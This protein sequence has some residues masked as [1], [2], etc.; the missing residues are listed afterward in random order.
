MDAQEALERIAAFDDLTVSSE[1]L[2]M[3]AQEWAA[4][5]ALPVER[6]EAAAATTADVLPAVVATTIAKGPEAALFEEQ[7]YRLNRVIVLSELARAAERIWDALTRDE[8][9]RCV[10]KAAQDMHALPTVLSAK[11]W[12]AGNTESNAREAVKSVGGGDWTSGV[13]KSGSL[14]LAWMAGCRVVGDVMS[15]PGQAA[16]AL[17][18]RRRWPLR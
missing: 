5:I 3:N 15:T 6:I 17:G 2:A 18:L 10:E 11:K 12:L 1:L 7:L 8:Q 16:K 14:S 4:V 13:V 9:E